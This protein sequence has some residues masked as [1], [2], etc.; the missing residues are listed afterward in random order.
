MCGGG[1]FLI[2][3]QELDGPG[4]DVFVGVPEELNELLFGLARE[5]FG[6][7]LG[8]E[9]AEAFGRGCGFFKEV[10]TALACA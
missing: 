5:A 4:A 2:L 7:V 10:V 3:V 8:P 1:W 6:D 9:G